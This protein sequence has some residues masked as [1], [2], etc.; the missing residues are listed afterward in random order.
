MEPKNRAVSPP[1]SGAPARGF[2]E[3][4]CSRLV[5]TRVWGK[6]MAC[7]PSLHLRI[8]EHEPNI[9]G[10]RQLNTR[11]ISAEAL[12]RVLEAAVPLVVGCCSRVYI[13]H[14]VS[15]LQATRAGSGSGWLDGVREMLYIATENNQSLCT[16]YANALVMRVLVLASLSYIPLPW[17][18]VCEVPTASDRV[19]GDAAQSSCADGPVHFDNLL[20]PC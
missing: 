16:R 2:R 15:C 12:C 17:R 9:A 1:A 14:H 8:P 11:S 19:S 5:P 13:G 6:L 3:S 7:M 10:L 20:A 4:R 18:I